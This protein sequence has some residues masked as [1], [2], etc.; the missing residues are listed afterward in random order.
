MSQGVVTRKIILCGPYAGLTG[1]LREFSFVN[2]ELTITGQKEEV[3]LVGQFIERNWQGYFEGDP[4][5][6]EFQNGQRELQAGGGNAPGQDPVHGNLQP[7]LEGAGTGS[8]GDGSVAG[9]ASA[10]N[11][12]G[13][14]GGDGSASGLKDPELN[15]KLQRAVFSLDPKNDE[16]WTQ[17]GKPALIA[18]EKAYGAT[19][20]RRADVAAVAPEFTRAVATA[21]AAEAQA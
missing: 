18:V 10:G 13:E 21:K 2:G 20:V 3:D 19:G 8:A 14:A 6:E 5:I 1:S 7:N 12:G 9:D 4:R 15:E 11:A 16:H 17:D